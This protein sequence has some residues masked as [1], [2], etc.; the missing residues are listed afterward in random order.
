MSF[1]KNNF[2]GV[3]IIESLGDAMND[4]D[5][6]DWTIIWTLVLVEKCGFSFDFSSFHSTGDLLTVI[7]DTVARASN[8]SNRFKATRAEALDISRAFRRV[9]NAVF[10]RKPKSCRIIGEIFDLI[11]SFL[12]N[13]WIGVVLDGMSS[14]EFSDQAN[15]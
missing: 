11:S 13:G 4:C 3:H 12:S 14:Q 15:C 10:L 1:L 9:L 8:K 5:H 2:V 6:L 7:S